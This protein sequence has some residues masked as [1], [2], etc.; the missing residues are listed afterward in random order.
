MLR[1]HRRLA[2]LAT[3]DQL[4]GL[5][6][7]HGFFARIEA[8]RTDA[9]DQ[10]WSVLMI[11]VDHFKQIN[12]RYGHA[13]GDQCLAQIAGKLRD[14]IGPSGLAA[15]MGGE[16]FAVLLPVGEGLQVADLG[17]SLARELTL[18][19]GDLEAAIPVTLSI[20]AAPWTAARPFEEA[21]RQAD[22]ALY[23]AKAQGRAQLVR[24]A[25]G[26][27]PPPGTGVAADPGGGRPLS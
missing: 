2:V 27:V 9:P 23:Q 7:R 16:E 13:V 22:D 10:D 26:P 15:R 5:M 14:A 6:N 1:M 20:G 21:L 8:L 11:D 4:T 18:R 12:D 19:H 24:T 3:T 17:Q 25:G